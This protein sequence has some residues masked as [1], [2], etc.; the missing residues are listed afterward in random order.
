LK[1]LIEVYKFDAGTFDA[2]EGNV[3]HKCIQFP[4]PTA[5]K[6]QEMFDY[7]LSLPQVNMNAFVAAKSL[8]AT[9]G[10]AAVDQPFSTPLVYAFSE[11]ENALAL[12][13]IINFADVNFNRVVRVQV[14][15]DL[16]D[17]LRALFEAGYSK[18]LH[19]IAINA[20]FLEGQEDELLTDDQFHKYVASERR[21]M[22]S[23][24]QL[25]A[26]AVRRLYGKL[27]V[28]KFVDDLPQISLETRTALLMQDF[29][30]KLTIG[31][32][33]KLEPKKELDKSVANG[34]EA[35]GMDGEQQSMPPPRYGKVTISMR[36]QGLKKN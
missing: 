32:D 24:T 22:R 3:L 23:L 21:K 31:R 5:D 35:N 26:S 14:N 7:L 33:G 13:L 4:L 29:D 2:V 25:A 18:P 6:N 34:S 30:R 36:T 16:S 9:P 20:M 19:C 17:A 27:E 1:L 8:K 12:R 11:G 15:D 10:Q 28:E